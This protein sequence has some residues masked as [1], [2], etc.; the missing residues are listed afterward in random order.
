VNGFGNPDGGE[1]SISLVRE[2]DAVFAGPFYP[3]DDRGGS[4]VRGLQD[5]DMKIIIH[6]DRAS[7]RRHADRL[8]SDVEIVD[9]FRH[10]PVGDAVMAPGTEMKRNIIE[11][12]RTLKDEF[13]DNLI[14]D[15]R[16]QSAI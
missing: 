4:S 5:V 1:V 14:A 16:F 9:R 8:L 6:E 3:G 11:T 2:N 15:L 10:E 13:H 7:H 12:L